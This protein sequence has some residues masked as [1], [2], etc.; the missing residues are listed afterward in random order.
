MAPGHGTAQKLLIARNFNL[1][2]FPSYAEGR[3]LL[4][5]GWRPTTTFT[6]R[7]TKLVDPMPE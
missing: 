7:G 3:P 5:W 6:V 4:S 1:T 2:I